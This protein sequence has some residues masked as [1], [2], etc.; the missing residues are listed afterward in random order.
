MMVTP[1]GCQQ[2]LTF[3]NC[4]RY[5]ERMIGKEVP[6]VFSTRFLIAQNTRF[7]SAITLHKKRKCI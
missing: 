2:P 7:V 1:A 4:D 6:R 5:N 3:K